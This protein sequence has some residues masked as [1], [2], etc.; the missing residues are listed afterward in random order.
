[1]IF[2]T[3]LSLGDSYGKN[4]LAARRSRAIDSRPF[5]W[6]DGIVAE[7][8]ENT[9][10]VVK[11]YKKPKRTPELWPISLGYDVTASNDYRIFNADTQAEEAYEYMGKLRETYDPK[12]LIS[13]EARA[14]AKSLNS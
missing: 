1:M 13:D 14:L 5:R 8:S 12:N 6:S 4:T 11:Y 10:K 9:V 3:A 7:P 2:L